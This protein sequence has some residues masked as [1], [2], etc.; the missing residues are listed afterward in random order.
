MKSLNEIETPIL[1]FY[2]F[3]VLNIN[4]FDKLYRSNIMTSMVSSE[5]KFEFYT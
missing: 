5:F 3:I 4:D 2:V 1:F